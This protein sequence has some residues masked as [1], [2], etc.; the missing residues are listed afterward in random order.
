MMEK[1]SLFVKRLRGLKYP[2]TNK[3]IVEVLKLIDE[4]CNSCW[5]TQGPCTCMRD[6]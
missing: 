2:L 3:Q 5:D 1:N 6:E 4:I